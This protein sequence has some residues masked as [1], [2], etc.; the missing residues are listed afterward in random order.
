MHKIP[1]KRVVLGGK[2]FVVESLSTKLTNEAIIDH[3]YLQCK[4]QPLR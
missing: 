1:Y 3:L 4:Q 2:H